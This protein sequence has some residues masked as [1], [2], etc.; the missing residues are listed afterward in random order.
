MIRDLECDLL[1]FTQPYVLHRFAS[2]GFWKRDTDD[3]VRLP[4]ENWTLV[5]GWSL[6]GILSVANSVTGVFFMARAEVGLGTSARTLRS[7]NS[8]VLRS[9]LHHNTFVSEPACIECCMRGILVHDCSAR[10]PLGSAASI[11]QRIIS[12]QYRAVDDRVAKIMRGWPLFRHKDHF[13]SHVQ[14]SFWDSA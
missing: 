3:A 11:F 12:T 10:V 4:E 14:V 13:H 6:S 5:L 8:P 7:S 2:G 1:E 9:C